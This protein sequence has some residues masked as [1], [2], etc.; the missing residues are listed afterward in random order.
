MKN[1]IK[2]VTI[3]ILFIFL[4]I[5]AEAKKADN[6]VRNDK[7]QVTKIVKYYDNDKIKQIIKYSYFSNNKIKTKTVTS[8]TLKGVKNSYYVKNNYSN[9]KAKLAILYS[10]YKKNIYQSK[11]TTK[12]YSNGKQS[13]KEF[14]SR[15]TDKVRIVVKQYYYNKKG[16]L[17]TNNY[18]K[19]KRLEYKY[20]NNNKIKAKKTC[21]YQANGKSICSKWETAKYK[22]NKPLTFGEKIVKAGKTF[23]GD[24]MVC[25]EFVAKSII[26]A[27]YKLDDHNWHWSW[28]KVNNHKYKQ[29][30]FYPVSYEYSIVFVVKGSQAHQNLLDYFGVEGVTMKP[31]QIKTVKNYSELIKKLQVGDIVMYNYGSHEAVYMGNGMAIQGGLADKNGKYQRVG[32]APLDLGK[33]FVITDFVRIYK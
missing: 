29:P 5:N 13:F 6:I 30:I 10:N 27:G 4:S 31:S 23:N 8:Y 25:T 1:I 17:K 14:S 26:K 2:T 22:N 33:D 12:Y 7:N 19:A 21:N 24:N 32:I 11:V 9:G 15:N 3:L 16:Q 18:G 20:Y 28:G